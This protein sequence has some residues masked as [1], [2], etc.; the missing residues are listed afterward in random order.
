MYRIDWEALNAL[1]APQRLKVLSEIIASVQRVCSAERDRIIRQLVDEYGS[2]KAAA[3]ALGITPARVNQIMKEKPVKI[4]E[5]TKP[6]ELYRRYPGQTSPQNCYIELDLRN[7][8][9]LAD[10]DSEVGGAVPISVYHGFERR[11]PIPVLTSAAANDL[12][13]Q[14]RPLAERILSDWEE[15]WDGNNM[16]AVLGDD[17]QAAE[18]EIENTLGVDSSEPNAGFDDSELVT[19]WGV[20]GAISGSEVEDYGITA[21]TSDERLEEIAE[22][23]RTQLADCSPSGEAIVDDEVLQY[24]VRERDELAEADE[25]E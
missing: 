22:D 18:A 3:A 5:C 23:I 6:A 7:R 24:L 8:T 10:Y 19:A 9:L 11:Y 14:I 21:D 25:D 13:Q 1:P 20:D 4:I 17:A 2:Q 15:E 12:M 16:K